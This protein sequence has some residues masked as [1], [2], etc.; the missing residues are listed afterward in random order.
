MKKTILLILAAVMVSIPLSARDIRISG[1]AVEKATGEPLMFSTLTVTD[2]RDSV[3]FAGLIEN[4][5]A[6]FSFEGVSIGKGN[7]TITI[8]NGFD[9]LTSIEIDGAEVP[10]HLELG[11]VALEAYTQSLDELTV[12]ASAPVERAVG[13]DIYSVDSALLRGVVNTA[14][15]INNVPLLRA[16]DDGQ[17]ATIIGK[18]NVLILVN[19]INTGQYVDLRR[20]NFRNIEKVEVVTL[21]PSNIDKSYDG[22]I[23]LVFRK[24]ITTG[25]EA[26][27]NETFRAPSLDNDFIGGV[28][29]GTD[30]VKFELYYTNY[31]R[32]PLFDMSNTR[33]DLATGESYHQDGASR[34]GLEL[35]HTVNFNMDWY[36]SQWDYFNITTQ[37][38]ISDRGVKSF[39]FTQYY[40]DAAG[41]TT[42]VLDSFNRTAEDNY[43][44]GNYTM[45]YRH[46][47]REKSTDYFSATANI[48][49][50]D[51]FTSY[52]S[53]YGDD[54]REVSSIERSD[55]LSA[56]LILDYHNKLSDVL[57][58]DVGAQGYWRNLHSFVDG[59]ADVTN[60]YENWLYNAFADLSVDFDKFAFR[61]GL[62]GE[63]NTNIFHDA[64]LGSNTR[65][66]F[67]PSAGA[68]W[69]VD[70]RNSL[71][72][73]YRRG[74]YYP[75]AWVL[76]P[77]TVQ[78]D[79]K[80][81][82]KGNPELDPYIMNTFELKYAYRSPKLTFSTGFN[83]WHMKDVHVINFDYDSDLNATQSYINDGALDRLCWM[84]AGTYSPIEWMDIDPTVMLYY[85]N[86][87]TLG[88]TRNEFTYNVGLDLTFYLP[89]DITLSAGASYTS[90]M[91]TMSG[92]NEPT[93]NVSS[94]TLNK[95]FPS[96]GSSIYMSYWCP[97][98]SPSV[99]HRFSGGVENIDYSYRTNL[100][101]FMIGIEIYF[102]NQKELRR[103]SVRTYFDTDAGR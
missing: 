12:E 59:Q 19:G 52:L 84:I 51:G 23:N 62:K 50:T 70:D 30:K 24:E 32:R 102:M 9:L 10:R 13:R 43:F 94:V 77:Y 15:L 103:S 5:D 67:Q 64:A 35:S 98:E 86:F 81:Y 36:I 72:F 80:T 56:N 87:R 65:I 39:D 82:F 68:V 60:N 97:L 41:D 20:I 93:Y 58:L 3:V 7:Y 18:N 28:G 17:T 53:V 8:T 2:A 42:S 26:L 45:Y 14:D 95:Y 88:Q 91:L 63:G 79:E 44:V 74:A 92:Y 99:S 29:F 76:T 47:M 61:I 6:S 34:S 33:T 25:V 78:I 85:D 4:E 90:R 54:V 75:S 11:T 16:S 71:N 38:D 57:T 96:L 21:P 31:Y 37:T 83:Y 69:R 27:I 40:T 100:S 66:S 55:R 89:W 73:Q 48:G 1:R 22:V 101:G 49:Y 46:T